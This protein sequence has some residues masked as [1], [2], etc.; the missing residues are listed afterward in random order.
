MLVDT[1]RVSFRAALLIAAGSLIRKAKTLLAGEAA[2]GYVP[3]VPRERRQQYAS[4][5]WYCQQ[6]DEDHDL[7]GTDIGP[8]VFVAVHPCGCKTLVLGL[9]A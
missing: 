2:G 1:E 6:P 9:E 7:H 3:V 5:C 8:S 4:L